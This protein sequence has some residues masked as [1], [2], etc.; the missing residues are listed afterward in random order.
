MTLLFDRPHELAHFDKA[1]SRVGRRGQL[2]LMTGRRGAGK[3][4]LIQWWLSTRRK[5]A[6]VWTAQDGVDELQQAVS[7]AQ[8]LGRYLRQD[9]APASPYASDVWRAALLQLAEA[10]ETHRPIV[11]IDQA[12]AIMPTYSGLVNG[13]KRAWDDQL[14]HR[15]V[16]LILIGDDGPRVFEHLRSYTRAPLYGR[17]T[18]LWRVHPIAWGDFSAT[19]HRW[20]VRDRLWAYGASGGWPIFVKAIQPSE[21]AR[22]GVG[23][24]ADSPE[25]AQS[26]REI[27]AQFA[28]TRRA[29]ITQTLRTLS[30]DA[31]CQEDLAQRSHLP[32]RTLSKALVDLE[33]SELVSTDDVPVEAPLPWTQRV[34]FRLTDHQMR[35]GFRFLNT[36]RATPNTPKGPQTLDLAPAGVNAYLADLAT[37]T[38]LIPW[39]FL[40]GPRGK[41]REHIDQ[42]GPLP[43]RLPC[44]AA[45]AALDREHHRVLVCGAFGQDRPVGARRVRS[46]VTQASALLRANWPQHSGRILVL[47]LSGYSAPIGG[48]PLTGRLLLKSAEPMVRDLARWAKAPTTI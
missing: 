22:R 8:A 21:S 28:K 18:A 47:S 34:V 35:F 15:A 10:A 11:V 25:Y 14:Q 26:V 44:D 1:L 17:F 42:V 38:V 16:L 3:T 30:Q 12:T 40:A 5:R 29:A 33:L 23:Q 24:L 19:F 48:P 7:F 39:L 46:F 43:T 20:P 27:V 13:L 31:G 37:E 41:L 6:L 32:R 9:P 45:L 2:C 36:L 4:T